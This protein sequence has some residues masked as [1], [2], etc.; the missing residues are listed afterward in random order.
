V[1]TEEF[2]DIREQVGAMNTALF[3]GCM[4]RRASHPP[5]LALSLKKLGLRLGSEGKMANF[6]I[7]F[8]I[9]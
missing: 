2:L 1:H 7:N 3:T 4:F 5:G 6:E 8:K 9:L